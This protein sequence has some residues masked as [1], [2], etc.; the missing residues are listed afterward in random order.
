MIQQTN[1]MKDKIIK[2]YFKYN[3]F[4]NENYFNTQIEK[5]IAKKFN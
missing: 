5:C 3:Q 1:I 4:Y 2:K